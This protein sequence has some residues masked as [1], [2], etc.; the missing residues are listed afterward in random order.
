M[1]VIKGLA[2]AI[3]ELHEMSAA[4]KDASP[5]ME[6]IASGAESEMKKNFQGERHIGGGKFR[7]LSKQ[8]AARKAKRYPGKTI[9]RATDEG[10]ASIVHNSGATFAEAGPTDEKM[11]YHADP[12]EPH[13]VMPYRNP[14]FVLPSS[15]EAAAKAFADFVGPR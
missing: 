6:E 7:N 3:A 12:E 4:A 2:E 9:L 11:R 5:I 10:Y 13:P 1:A 14:F 8:Y 15:E